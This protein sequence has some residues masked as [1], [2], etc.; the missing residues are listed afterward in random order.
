[1]RVFLKTMRDMMKNRTIQQLTPTR[2][3]INAYLYRHTSD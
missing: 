1:M 3:Y 2:A